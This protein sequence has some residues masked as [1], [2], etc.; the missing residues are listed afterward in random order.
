MLGCVFLL[1]TS[2]YVMKTAREGLILAHGRFGL[3]GQ[4]LRAYANGLMAS[5]EC[6]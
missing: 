1:L 2:S 6:G 3:T 5:P 4:E